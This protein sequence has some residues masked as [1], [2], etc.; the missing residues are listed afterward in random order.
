MKTTRSKSKKVRGEA[1]AVSFRLQF[2]FVAAVLVAW[3]VN[4]T[5]SLTVYVFNGAELRNYSYLILARDLF[6]LVAFAVALISVPKY[7]QPISSL[8]VALLKAMMAV[9]LLGVLVNFKNWLGTVMFSD[10]APPSSSLG[11][12]ASPWVD[13]VLM[14]I[15]LFCM[16]WLLRDRFFKRG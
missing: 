4:L 16:V 1:V 3:A 9:L 7:S 13:A 15:T 2:A 10:I 11:W 5:Y 8:F 12:F 6:P 14:A